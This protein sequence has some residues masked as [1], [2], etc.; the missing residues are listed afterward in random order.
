MDRARVVEFEGEEETPSPKASMT[1]RKYFAGSTNLSAPA[2]RA[3]MVALLPLNQVGK[4]TA[5]ERSA[6]SLPQVR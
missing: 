2:A 1:T 4:K 6:L 5:L 3:P